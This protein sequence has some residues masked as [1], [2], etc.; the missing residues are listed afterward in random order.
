MAAQDCPGC[1]LLLLPGPVCGPDDKGHGRTKSAIGDG[2]GEHVM[3]VLVGVAVRK[4][5]VCCSS[6]S[7]RWVTIVRKAG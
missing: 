3:S 4:L 2:D 6:D 5:R 7:D 1:A